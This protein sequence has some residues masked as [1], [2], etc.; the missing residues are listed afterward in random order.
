MPTNQNQND[1]EYQ[2]GGLGWG[3]NIASGAASGALTGSALG[4]IG[5][6]VGGVL[7]AGA[8][9]IQS[10][11]Q[12][13]ALDAEA[14][15]QAQ[16]DAELEQAAADYD[17]FRMGANLAT[18][19]RGAAGELAAKQSAARGN[20]TAGS[21]AQLQASAAADQAAAAVQGQAEMGMAAQQAK[22]MQQ[23]QLL[24]EY[25]TAQDLA[26][27]TEAGADIIGSMGAIGGNLAELAGKAK[28]GWGQTGSA[29]T[30]AADPAAAARTV[31]TADSEMARTLAAQAVPAG[32]PAVDFKSPWGFQEMAGPMQPYGE[33]GQL[34]GLLGAPGAAQAFAP[35][36]LPPKAPGA[37]LSPPSAPINPAGWV[38]GQ[39]IEGTGVRGGASAVQ[40]EARAK[41]D[42]ATAPPVVA[43][44]AEQEAAIVDYT[45][46]DNIRRDFATSSPQELE[47]II[48]DP[49][50]DKGAAATM[51]LSRSYLQSKVKSINDAG[52][53]TPEV[54]AQLNA[55]EGIQRSL[56]IMTGVPNAT[57]VLKNGL[58]QIGGF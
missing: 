27:G 51:M 50:F 26:N 10:L 29:T 37:L 18:A 11:S 15:R 55:D 47:R 33:A 45:N 28:T 41:A 44:T 35:A 52:T 17:L 3:T 42:A 57:L 25:R 14:A 16:L 20:L 6:G 13:K 58:I 48:T 43:P 8:G 21:S 12:Q 32:G 19:Q 22:L 49:N 5:A 38:S 53:A 34:P 23:G 1:D 36:A 2:L 4:P 31:P 40:A 46:V 54:V 56:R 24:N 30:P 7:G 9:V 39:G